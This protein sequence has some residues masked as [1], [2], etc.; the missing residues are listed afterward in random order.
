MMYLSGWKSGLLPP[1]VRQRALPQQA[2]RVP[3]ALV[4]DE[5]LV[6]VAR[7]WYASSSV[8]QHGSRQKDAMAIGSAL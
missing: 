4:H 3:P 7:T 1:I 8:K 2:N 5:R 6:R